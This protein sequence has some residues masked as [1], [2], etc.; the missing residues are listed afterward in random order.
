LTPEEHRRQS[1][2][3]KRR[4]RLR[5]SYYDINYRRVN[6]EKIR[7]LSKE[8]YKKNRDKVLKRTRDYQKQNREQIKIQKREYRKRTKERYMKWRIQYYKKNKEKLLEK[9]RQYY[10]DNKEKILK[11]CEIYRKNNPKAGGGGDNIEMRITMALRKRLDNSTCQWY[12]CGKTGKDTTIDVH[13]IFPKSEYPQYSIKLE[14]MICYC[15]WHHYLWHKSRGD[16]NSASFL[17]YNK[18]GGLS[19]H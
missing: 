8:H 7:Q 4:Q 2:E 6:A 1:R 10:R 16:K 12:N 14:Y 15:R 19:S 17:Y 18:L 5:N 9:G 3:A 13:H 11:R